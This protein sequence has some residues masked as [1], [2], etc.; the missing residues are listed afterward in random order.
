MSMSVRARLPI[1]DSVPLGTSLAVGLV[2]S[3]CCGGGLLFGAIGLGGFYG[4]LG[5]SRYIPQ[6][7]A[8]G[9][10]LI[11]LV[12]WLYYRSKAARVLAGDADC[13]CAAFR[14]A[15]LLSSFLGLIMMSISFV[16]LEWL[17]HAVVNAGR[18]MGHH[19]YAGAVIPGVP[20]EHLAY[21]AATFLV[22][23]LLAI[24]P[25]PHKPDVMNPDRI[26]SGHGVKP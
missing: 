8:G 17:N 7:L 1:P 15:M 22:V 16:L 6:A 10:I 9:A 13:D 4:A 25:L 19:Q 11:A 23:P 3:L 21:L 2:S 14:R 18:F 26:S 24:L 12:N 5:L 20:N